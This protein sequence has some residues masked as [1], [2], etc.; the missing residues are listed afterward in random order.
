MTAGIL[1]YGPWSQEDEIE[2]GKQLR[3]LAAIAHLQL[4]A[5]HPLVAQ[6]RAAETDPICLTRAREIIE[7]LPALT[8][9]HLL[10]AFSILTWPPRARAMA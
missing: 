8:R 9:R 5:N 7:A 1:S 10:A 3:T 6:L 4:G 2:R